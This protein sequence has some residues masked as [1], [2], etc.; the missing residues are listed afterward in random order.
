M[1]RLFKNDYSEC[2]HE[3][4]LKA[5]IDIK[6]EQNI[7]YV[8]D[9]HSKAAEESILNVFGCKD[10]EV[11]FLTGGTQANMIVLSYLLK[12][13]E[14][15][16][17]CDTGHINVHETGAVEGSGHK[18]ITCEN[19][20]GKLVPA[21]VRTVYK[22]YTDEHMVSPKAIYISNSTEVGTV[23]TKKELIEL[24]KVC[25]DLGLYFFIDGARLA[26]ALTCKENDVEPSFL[27]KICDA[28]YVGGTKNGFLSGEAVVFTNKN[29]CKDFR[30][31]IK[32]RGGMLAKG[33]VVGAQFERAFK[34]NLY[35]D[36][37]INS[38]KTAEYIRDGLKG[39][40]EFTSTS[41]TNQ[42]FIKL[43]S[44]EAEKVM[45]KFGC[46]LW[47][48]L[49]DKKIIRIVTSFA[50]TIPDCD[51]LIGFVKGL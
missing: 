9:K 6:N 34:D 12:P 14:A 11:F 16:I 46:E 51:E 13:Y 19:E 33:F 25:D 32:N 24:R 18:I 5:I 41:P 23:Y 15:V 26:V 35:F 21:K 8:L 40:V 31:H 2:A 17:C 28:F 47:E 7:G 48:D 27:G 50:T 30:Y 43:N 42:I 10:G 3:E 4:I 37:S 39:V 1:S 36:I 45:D 29:L 44:L 20:N 22:K 49:G 38:N